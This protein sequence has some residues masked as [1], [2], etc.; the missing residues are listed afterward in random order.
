MCGFVGYLGGNQF[1]STNNTLKGMADT[2]IHRGPD[3]YGAWF[4]EEA[5]IALA[6]RRLSILELTEAG[7]QPMASTCGRYQCV[8]NA[9]GLAKCCTRLHN[10]GQI[11]KVL[12]HTETHNEIKL[13]QSI[14]WWTEHV[15]TNRLDV[16]TSF[17]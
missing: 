14:F 12:N 6:H 11:C 5:S 2:I 8:K 1:E 10:H 15:C 3:A 4:D 16:D 17:G 7:A 9:T 13:A